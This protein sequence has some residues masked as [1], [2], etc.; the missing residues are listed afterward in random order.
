MLTAG[1]VCAVAALVIVGGSAFVRI[2]SLVD[3]R[4]PVEQAHRVLAELSR[5]VS[6]VDDAERGQRGFVITGDEQYLQPYQEAITAIPGTVTV[7]EQLTAGDPTQR[8]L[9]TQLRAPL[10]AKL[11]ELAETVTLRRTRGF[12]AAQTVVNTD[13]GAAYMTRV[14]DTIEAMRRHEQQV[15]DRHLQASAA[16]GAQ[17]RRVILW[18]SLAAALL[19]GAGAGWAT[20]KVSKSISGVTAAA[21][22]VIAGQQAPQ[23]RVQG[24]AEITEM[25][26]AVNTATETVLAARDEAVNAAQ[27]KSAFLATMSHEIRTPMNAVIGMTGLLLDTELTAEQREYVTTVRDSGEALL[28]IINDILDFSKIESGQ[29][30]LEDATFELRDCI[31]SSLALVAVHA[32]DKGLELIAQVDASCPALLRGDVTRL[33]QILVNLLSNAV[34]FTATGEVVVTA[35]AEH[36]GD[37]AVRLHLAVRDT[38]IGIPADRTDRLFRSFSQIDNSTT[39]LYG[40]TGLGLAISRRL[41]QA[42]D[43]DITVTSTPGVGSTFTTTVMLHACPQPAD[44]VPATPAGRR[45]LIVD[46]NATNRAVLQTQLTS[47]GITCVAVGGAAEALAAIDNGGAFDVAVLDMHMPD[48]DGLQLAHMLH[49]R[50]AATGVTLMPLVLLSSVTWRPEPGQR[51]VFAAVMAKPVR[52][53]TL[54]TTLT[55]ILTPELAAGVA[56]PA[57]APPVARPARVLRI[58]LA[59]DNQINQK[60]AQ[61][62]LAKLGHRVDAVANGLE[63]VHA[64]L[65]ADYDVVLMDMQMPVLDGLDA[66]RR[67]RAEIPGA[68][69]PRIIAMTANALQE[70]RAACAAAG[71]DDFLAKPVRPSDLAAALDSAADRTPRDGDPAGKPVTEPAVPQAREH[72]IRTRLDEITDGDPG[73]A[74]RRLLNRILT[75]FISKTPDSVTELQQ[76]LTTGDAGAVRDH[77]HAMKGSAANLGATTLAALLADLEHTARAGKLPEPDTTVAALRDELRQLLPVLRTIAAELADEHVPA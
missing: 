26:Q 49:A 77:A 46:D 3:D 52:P 75:S 24:T 59:E 31:D 40:G 44:T 14:E 16:A 61:T 25:A 30:D 48:T 74:E 6:Q 19:V 4:V 10:H 20:R 11:D 37:E 34:K 29:L 18:G 73:P 1:Y 72:A 39:R 65:R 55:Q 76:L 38:G 60:V 32:A 35:T 43:G 54:R 5:L 13:R 15:L 67:I 21:R 58:L 12:A 42:M 36:H 41:A 68:R 28:V 53:A 8:R 23:H 69:Q 22:A 33:R 17:T 63:A 66:T 7:I 47:W 62:M 45:V 2:G 50:A 56:Q 51:D 27:A 70:D 71:M 57:T 9:L 64:M